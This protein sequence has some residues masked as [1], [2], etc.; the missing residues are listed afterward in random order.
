[1]GGAHGVNGGHAPPQ[2]PHSY[3]TAFAVTSIIIVNKLTNIS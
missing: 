2:T 3:A 1:M